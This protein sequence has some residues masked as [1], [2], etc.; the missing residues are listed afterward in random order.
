MQ[1]CVVMAANEEQ[2]DS[3]SDGDRSTSNVRVHVGTPGPAVA[4]ETAALLNESLGSGFVRPS[5]L[6]ELTVEGGGVV[7]RARGRGGELLG[8]ATA[9]V[10][11]QASHAALQD[12]LRLA[13]VDAGLAG[14]RSGELKSIVVAPAARGMGVGSIMLAASLDFLKARG[15]RD[16]VSASWVSANPQHS[17]LRMLERAGFG[18]VAT[19]PAFWADDQKAAG[20][21]CPL[22]GAECVCAAVILV[23]PFEDRPP[24]R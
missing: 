15:C 13:G 1:W 23:L 22:C 16:V 12:R 4:G 2:H 11:D 19:I 7:I 17:S 8:A 10:L 20:Y 5:A 14:C 9:R 24:G 18:Q 21:L 6:T 3:H